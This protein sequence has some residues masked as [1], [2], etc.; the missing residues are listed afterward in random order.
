[1]SR[2]LVLVVT[3]RR[4]RADQNGSI[5]RRNARHEVGVPKSRLKLLTLLK[6]ELA[7]LERGGY[8]GALPWRPVSLFVDSPTCPNRLDAEQ[9]TPCAECLL[10]QF[11]PGPSQQELQPCHFIPLNAAGETIYSMS[12]QYTQVEVEEAVRGWL[13]AEI[14]RIEALEDQPERVASGAN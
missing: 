7:F 13:K 8:G 12:R 1:V 14:Q 2:S 9:S 4:L 3:E 5:A 10:Y 11:V 6:L